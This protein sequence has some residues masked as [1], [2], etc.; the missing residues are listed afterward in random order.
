MEVNSA[1][2]T[3]HTPTAVPVPRRRYCAACQAAPVTGP[4]GITLA[5]PVEAST[6]TNRARHGDRLWPTASNWRCTAAP[7]ASDTTTAAAAAP[8]QHKRSPRA[9]AN[10]SPT[11]P[12]AGETDRN[13]RAPPEPIWP[14]YPRAPQRHRQE[15]PARA[16]WPS[17]WPPWSDWR[18]RR[19]AAEDPGAP[20]RVTAPGGSGGGVMGIAR[21]VPDDHRPPQRRA[22]RVQDHATSASAGGGDRQAG[23]HYRPRQGPVL[24]GGLNGP[25]AIWLRAE[26]NRPATRPAGVQPRLGWNRLGRVSAR[27][28]GGPAWHAAGCRRDH[29]R[30]ASWRRSCQGPWRPARPAASSTK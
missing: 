23:D 15:F 8:S 14:A 27:V 11:S 4:A 9:W 10:A 25:A 19:A 1:A 28:C 16:G 26:G 3:A 17:L 22:A 2:I 6:R 30:R 5:S 21:R 29:Y 20:D 12:A 24:I 18:H 13:R 7:Q